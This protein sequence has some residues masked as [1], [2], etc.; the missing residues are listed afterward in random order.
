MREV[1]GCCGTHLDFRGQ[2]PLAFPSPV[3]NYLDRKLG[4]HE[5]LVRHHVAT[6]FLRAS[7]DSMIKAASS[8]GDLLV[9]D[10]SPTFSNGGVVIAAVEGELGRNSPAQGQ[11]DIQD[12]I[13][14]GMRLSRQFFIVIIQY[15]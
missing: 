6:F 10:C 9:V 8:T 15:S 5:H 13:C 3:E 2:R 1:V 7:G 12:G 11:G 4:L 14:D